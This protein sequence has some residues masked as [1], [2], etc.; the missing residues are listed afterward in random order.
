MSGALCINRMETE[1]D[2]VMSL[3]EI[4]QIVFQLPEDLRSASTLNSFKPKGEKK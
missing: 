4:G 3:P 1:N 2:E